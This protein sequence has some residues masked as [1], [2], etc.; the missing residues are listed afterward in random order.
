[1]HE[2]TSR[3]NKPTW[4]EKSEIPA[5]P[6]AVSVMNRSHSTPPDTAKSRGHPSGTELQGELHKRT[7]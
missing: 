7:A 3:C 2:T 4:K 5:K 1:M 6:V